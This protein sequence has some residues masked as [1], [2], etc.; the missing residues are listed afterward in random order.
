MSYS[1]HTYKPPMENPQYHSTRSITSHS[2]FG[3]VPTPTAPTAPVQETNF[4]TTSEMQKLRNELQ[5]LRNYTDK[6]IA[7]ID[8]NVNQ[9]AHSINTVQTEVTNLN[10]NLTA[11]VT[12]AVMAAMALQMQHSNQALKTILHHSTFFQPALEVYPYYLLLGQ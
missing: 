4:A 5:N 1:Q 11:S 10:K 3:S 8:N 12:E 9:V 2:S 7:T 6:K